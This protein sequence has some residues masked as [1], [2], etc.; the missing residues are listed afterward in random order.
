[1]DLT[2]IFNQ[3]LRHAAIPV[4]ELKFDSAQGNVSYRWKVDEPGFAMPVRVGTKDNWLIIQPTT[5]WKTMKTPLTK[6]QFEVATDLYYV[7]VT[8]E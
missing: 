8:K 3:Y 4:L 5:E 2:P 7:D 1:M 6:D